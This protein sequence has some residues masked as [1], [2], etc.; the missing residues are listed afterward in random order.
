MG[1]INK[2]DVVGLEFVFATYSANRNIQSD[3]LF[4]KEKVHL[5]DGTIVPN[6][7]MLKDKKWPFYVTRKAHRNHNDHK[8][9]E[10]LSK[11]QRFESTRIKLPQAIAAATGQY[12]QNKSLRDIANWPYLYGLDILPTSQIKQVYQTK[13]KDIEVSTSTVA[14][15]DIETDMVWGTE[16]VIMTNITMRGKSYTAVT[17]KFIAGTT[18]FI[19]NTKELAKRLVPKD[20]ENLDWEIEIVET[21]G[22]ACYKVI[23]K[24]HQW[25]PDYI[26][27]WNMNFDIPKIIQTLLDEGYDPAQVFSDPS[28]PPEYRFY[29]YIEGP[30]IKVT[31]DGR[32]TSIHHA[33]RW[34]VMSCPASFYFLDSMC[35]RKRI[36]TASGNEPSYKLNEILAKEGLETKLSIKEAEALESDG[37]AWHFTLQKYYKAEYT[38]YNLIDDIR[39]LDYDEKTGDISRVFN[40]LAG[41]T[42]YSNYHKNPRRIADDLHYFYLERGKVVGS[43]PSSIADDPLNKHLLSLRDWIVTLPNYMINSGLN[44]IEDAPHIQTMFYQYLSD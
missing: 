28:V 37:E 33:D 14:G 3:A 1:K 8:E 41:I 31:H 38:I 12:T 22:E 5:K 13:Y 26:S 21:P 25:K 11:L 27:I 10:E 32:K 17:K 2:E 30:S 44:L 36:R 39:L 24:A 20:V 4:I 6:L 29:R 35:L 23:E 9:Y 40:I 16:E 19:E 42:D 15:L 7:R 18:N 43:T 34:H